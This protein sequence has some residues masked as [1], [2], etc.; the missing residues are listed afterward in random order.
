M[1]SAIDPTKPS[2]PVAYTADV[3]ANF[4]AAKS[5]IEAL[6]NVSASIFVS[7]DPPTLVAGLLW[8]CSVDLQL[9]IAYDDG[10]SLQWVSAINQTDGNVMYGIT[11]TDRSGA[12]T[13]GNTAQQLMAANTARRGWSL[14]NKSMANFWFN[15]LGGIASPD[16]N[17][18]TYM[19][20]GAYYESEEQ[21]A[22]VT[23]ISVI[24]DVTGAQFV[25]KEW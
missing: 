25:A 17:N 22:S 2:G 13:L 8:F 21:G 15:D 11:K 7:D 3:R 19:P 14:Q 18:S 4:A 1:T 24:A 16:A 9:Y 5:E 6:Q 10:S 12:I 23:S 20:P